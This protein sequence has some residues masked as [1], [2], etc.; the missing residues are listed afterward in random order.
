MRY[1]RYASLLA[2]LVIG[3]LMLNGCYFHRRVQ[4]HEVGLRMSD[5][6]SIDD[7]VGAGRYTAWSPWAR[8]EI[9]DTSVRTTEWVGSDV[10]TSDRQPVVFTVTVSYSRSRENIHTIWNMFRLE[11]QSDA[12]LERLVH[13][14]IPRVIRNVSTTM[15]LYDMLG[16]SENPEMGRTALTLAIFAQLEQE[17]A[18][19]GIDLHDV[20]VNDI[21]A[22]PGYVEMLIQRAQAGVMVDL[23]AART[24]ELEEQLRQEQAQTRI[25]VEIA[26]RNNQVMEEENRIF[27][28]STEAFELERLRIIAGA[29]RPTDTIYFIP[30]GSSLSLILGGAAGIPL[31]QQVQPYQ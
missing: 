27:A 28:E 15:S 14:R 2:F 11:A 1:L 8:L 18:T 10:W 31:Q 30:E 23:A 3:M 16:I 20:G 24:R 7:V 29:I 5:G 26:R 13:S 19:A 6:V 25:D 4:Q 9:V 21:S 12:A 17:L 22:D